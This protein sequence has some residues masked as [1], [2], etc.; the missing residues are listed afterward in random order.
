MTWTTPPRGVLLQRLKTEPPRQVWESM[1]FEHSFRRH[2]PDEMHAVAM[3]LMQPV[4]HNALMLADRLTDLGWHALTPPMVGQPSIRP[5]PGEV[6]AED[7]GP[8]PLALVSFWEVVGGLNFVWDYERGP[9]PD[10]FGGYQIEDLDPLWIDP[11]EILAYRA[12]EWQDLRNAGEIDMADRVTLDLA[13][14][15]Q[16]KANISG[17][18]PYGLRLPDPELDPMFIGD[19]FAMRFVAYLRLS[20]RWAGFPGLATLP[21]SA[22]ADARVAQL[23]EG[24]LPF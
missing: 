2:D 15:A 12:R 7:Y 3:A 9:A 23:T 10:L 18:S 1:C 17:G 16:H 4:R 24:F 22:K 8:L 13:P 5:F 19:D 11:P 21:Q 20:F 14:D 6:D